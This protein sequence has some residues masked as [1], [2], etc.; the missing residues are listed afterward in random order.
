MT[1]PRALILHGISSIRSTGD[2]EVTAALTDEESRLPRTTLTLDTRAYEQSVESG[3]WGQ[4]DAQVRTFAA[5]VLANIEECGPATL[6]YVGVDEV[7]TLIALGAYVGDEHRVACRDYDRD[8]QIFRW[9][10]TVET[11]A[12]ESVGVPTEAVDSPG[13]VVLR[14]EI[15]YPVQSRDVDEAVRNRLAD[16]TIRPKGV[17]PT[18]GI[19]RSQV[20][21]EALRQEVRTVL[22]RI[23]K[24]RP[25]AQTIH[26]FLAGPVSACLAVGQELRLRN[27]RRVQTYRYRSKDSPPQT[28]SILLTPEA[29]ESVQAPLT[30]DQLA[31]AKASRKIWTLALADINEHAVAL[32]ANGAWPSYLMTALAEAKP[33]PGGLDSIWSL[34]SERHLIADDDVVEFHFDRDSGRWYLPDRMLLTMNMAADGNADRIQRLAR[35]FLWHEYLHE[36]QNLTE[37]TAVEVGGF[38]N[39]L[40]RLDYIADMYGTLHQVDFVLRGSSEPVDWDVIKQQLLVAITEAIDAFWTFEEPPPTRFWQTRRLRRY[41]NWYWRREQIIHAKTVTEAVDLLCEPPVIEIA[42]PVPSVD[43]RR[44]Y[45]DLERIRPSA[46]ELALVDNNN[47]LQ[48]FPTSTNLPIAELLQA[49]RVRDRQ[50]IDRF[51]KSLID[52]ARQRG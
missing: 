9:P 42:G 33:R 22:A 52:H 39:C 19:L 7:P 36:Y 40:E 26:L 49:F 30:P 10:E 51:F 50:G 20:D 37:N 16:I 5:K 29:T 44:Y 27:G 18:P 47:K 11:L 23:E 3:F 13:N 1:H 8:Q 12:F 25:S 31:V 45:A 48:R 14:I 15:S 21:L 24:V 6:L 35:A 17:A 32:R 2:A 46:L 38:P 41:L 28:R 34:V 4:V 43:T